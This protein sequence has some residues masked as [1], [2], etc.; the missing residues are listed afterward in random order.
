MVN[1]GAVDVG[2]EV[3]DADQRDLFGGGDA[4]GVGVADEQRRD[5]PGIAGD[6]DGVNLVE[7]KAGF[8]EGCVNDG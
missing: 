4:L 3:V 5:E 7:V 6:G 8:F 2:D 1:E